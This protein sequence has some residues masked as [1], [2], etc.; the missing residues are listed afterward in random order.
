[1]PA[2]DIFS[3]LQKGGVETLYMV[4]NKVFEGCN[5]LL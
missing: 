4:C 1:M 2:E 3:F 5:M